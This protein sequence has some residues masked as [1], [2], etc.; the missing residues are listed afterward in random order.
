MKTLSIREA[1]EAVG[2]APATIRRYIKSGRLRALKEQGKFGEEYRIREEDLGG[3][4][5]APSRPPVPREDRSEK[6]PP[7]QEIAARPLMEELSSRF[8]PR[9]LYSELSMKHERLLVQYGM[10]RAGGT[11]LL[12]AQADLARLDALLGEREKEIGQLR[13]RYEK[14]IGFL[15]DALRKAEI[16]IEDRNIEVTLLRDQ[17]RRVEMTAASAP[18]IRSFEEEIRAAE[19]A[20]AAPQAAPDRGAVPADTDTRTIDLLQDWLRAC[21]AERQERQ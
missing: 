8:V 18:A 19:A 16:E 17:I 2:R 3:L 20:S 13:E 9:D 5:V 14:E 21:E 4:G 7:R 11:K 10:V 15:Q 6:T 12:E 1:S